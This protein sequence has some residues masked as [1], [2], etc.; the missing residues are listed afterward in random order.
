MTPANEYRNVKGG[1]FRRKTFMKTML[2]APF[3]PNVLTNPSAMISGG[4][5]SGIAERESRKRLPGNALFAVKNA[6]GIPTAAAIHVEPSAILN[7]Y[8]VVRTI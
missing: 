3:I 1:F 2:R 4:I 7:V 8:N 5:Q 6:A